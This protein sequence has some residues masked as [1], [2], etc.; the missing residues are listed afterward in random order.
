MSAVVVIRVMG[1]G[2]GG[3]M[4]TFSLL[5]EAVACDRS[6]VVVIVGWDVVVAVERLRC[7]VFD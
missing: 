4:T 5:M 7:V 6:E 3:R 1:G 2:L